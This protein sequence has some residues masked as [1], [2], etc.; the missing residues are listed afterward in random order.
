MFDV[1]VYN[2]N[3]FQNVTYR[4]GLK[5][6]DAKKVVKE[7]RKLGKKVQ[8]KTSK[9]EAQTVEITIPEEDDGI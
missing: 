2:E 4:T 9:G 3:T 5:K 7:L 8:L 6:S 1:L